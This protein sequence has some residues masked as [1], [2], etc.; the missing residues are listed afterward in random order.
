MSLQWTLVATFLYV[1]IAVIIILLLPFISPTRF[2]IIFFK[3]YFST[4]SSLLISFTVA[5]NEKLD[6]KRFSSHE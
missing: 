4:L 3:A 6:G 5:Q 2:Y 1:E